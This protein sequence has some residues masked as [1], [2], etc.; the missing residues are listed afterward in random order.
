MYLLEDRGYGIR[1]VV[2]EGTVEECQEQAMLMESDSENVNGDG[3]P[4]TYSA[5]TDI[6]DDFY[7]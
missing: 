3:V 7:Y 1:Y 6:S 5:I 4:F 2:F